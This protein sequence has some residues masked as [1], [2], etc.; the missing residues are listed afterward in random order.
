V[1]ISMFLH[2]N[3]ED[4]HPPGTSVGKNPFWDAR[5]SLGSG[6]FDVLALE[7]R[8]FAPPWNKRWKKSDTV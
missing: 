3:Q 1:A 4:S 5:L 2:W 6:Y 8:G 7:S